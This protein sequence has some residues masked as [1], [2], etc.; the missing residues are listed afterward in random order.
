MPEFCMKIA[1]KIFVRIFWGHVLPP[2]PFRLL[3][4]CLSETFQWGR[5]P[6]IP[7][8]WRLIPFGDLIPKFIPRTRNLW[9]RLC[10]YR[11]TEDAFSRPG[12][13]NTYPLGEPK[14]VSAKL[15]L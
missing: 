14:P 7:I 12:I 15:D 2:S 10:A 8:I 1:R 4:L 3:R 13:Y 5:N 11:L 9:I 6:E